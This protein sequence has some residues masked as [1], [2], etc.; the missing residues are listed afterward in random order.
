MIEAAVKAGKLTKEEAAEKL[1]YLKKAAAAKSQKKPAPQKKVPSRSKLSDYQAIEAAVKS[2]K[3]TKEEAA[4]KLA[5]LKKAAAAKSQKKPA[6]PKK[7]PSKNSSQSDYKALEAAVKAGKL[8]KEEAVAKLAALKKN[9]STKSTKAA[10]KTSKLANDQAIQDKLAELVDSGLL[11]EA[12][13]KAMLAAA[14]K[15]G[16]AKKPVTK[17][18]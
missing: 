4:K 18:P 1:E 15:V 5:Y 11:S 7:A 8:T 13:A 12:Q 14:R 3:L 17:K 6:P 10:P 2:G 9:A 16:D